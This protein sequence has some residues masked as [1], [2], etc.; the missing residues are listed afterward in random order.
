MD[1][2]IV[3]VEESQNHFNC[4]ESIPASV[5]EKWFSS[6][7]A[8]LFCGLDQSAFVRAFGELLDHQIPVEK[9]RTG[10][11]RKTKYSQLCVELLQALIGGDSETF[12]R[13]KKSALPTQVSGVLSVSVGSSL[14]LQ[15]KI[16]TEYQN[17]NSRSTALAA[18]FQ[19]SLDAI[20]EQ[21]RIAIQRD[22]ILNQ[23]ENTAAKNRGALRALEAF[24]AEQSAYQ[25]LISRLRLAE[26]GEQ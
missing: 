24:E 26:L 1:L 17:S 6:A 21:R 3:D 13:L 5:P 16:E 15:Q 2:E 25:E 23:A 7:E 19:A 11:A 9:L 20:A 14:S 4:C 10:R 8:K 12:E 18:R 22:S